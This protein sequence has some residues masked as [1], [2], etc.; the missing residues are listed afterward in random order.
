ML[1]NHGLDGLGGRHGPPFRHA[2]L[3]PSTSHAPPTFQNWLSWPVG[4]TSR[5]PSKLSN[6]SRIVSRLPIWPIA[7]RWARSAGP[8]A[9]L[10]ALL[11]RDKNG[12]RLPYPR[13]PRAGISARGAGLTAFFFSSRFQCGPGRKPWKIKSRHV[14]ISAEQRLGSAFQP[15][16]FLRCR[17]KEPSNVRTGSYSTE[18]AY[19]GS[20]RGSFGQ[21]GR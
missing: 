13:D 21:S 18:W 2:G 3:S 10:T 20:A 6:A 14:P 1:L 7:R 9:K 17:R 11:S 15:A 16:L 4:R 12:R 5:R 19:Q 8:A